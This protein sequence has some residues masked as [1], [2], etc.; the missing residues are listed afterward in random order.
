MLRYD[1]GQ[2]FGETAA[3]DMAQRVDPVCCEQV[4]NR[5]NVDPGRCE[6]GVAKRAAVLPGRIEIGIA[7]IDNLANQ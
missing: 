1:S 3:G 5:P 6:Q 4:E 7:V 2:V